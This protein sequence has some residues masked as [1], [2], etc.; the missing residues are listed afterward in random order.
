MTLQE[1]HFF[2]I[3]SNFEKGPAF[4]L[5]H[6]GASILHLVT[7]ASQH[8]LAHHRQAFATSYLYTACMRRAP[9]T[10]PAARLGSEVRWP[11]EL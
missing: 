6:F 5:A 8:L 11:Q 9:H 2:N 10:M 3:R 7:A 1:V 4:Y